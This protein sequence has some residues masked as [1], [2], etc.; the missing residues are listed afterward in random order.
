MAEM[1]RERL[2]RLNA[3]RYRNPATPE[4]VADL[5][6]TVEA[7]VVRL[8]DARDKLRIIQIG[9]DSEGCDAQWAAEYSDR[10][11]YRITEFLAPYQ[12]ADHG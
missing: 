6:A 12:E 9:I 10:E 3:Q 1:N 5:I 2:D 11:V 4:D 7:L 8:G